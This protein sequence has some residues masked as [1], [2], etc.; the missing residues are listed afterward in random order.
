MIKSLR[1]L[2]LTLTGLCLLASPWLAA[3]STPQPLFDGLA[4]VAPGLDLSLIHI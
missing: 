4:R 3:A 1:R 2:G